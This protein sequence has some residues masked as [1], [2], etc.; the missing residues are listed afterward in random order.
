MC[1]KS[2]LA[3]LALTAVILPTA[4]LAA[5][6]YDV[7]IEVIREDETKHYGE[8]VTSDGNRARVDFLDDD[9]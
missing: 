2:R 3:S 4:A 7:N 6:R 1:V 8:R 9:G 5:L